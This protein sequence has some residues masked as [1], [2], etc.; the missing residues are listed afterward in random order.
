MSELKDEDF[1][2]V[3]IKGK[4]NLPAIG[5]RCLF[6]L[7]SWKD[8]PVR[9]GFRV[10]GYRDDKRTVYIPFY[11]TKLNVICVKSW[12]IEPGDTFHDGHI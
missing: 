9:N 5:Q 11:K 10:Y 1:Q 4:G 12:R 2:P 8:K 7:R 6:I 3:E